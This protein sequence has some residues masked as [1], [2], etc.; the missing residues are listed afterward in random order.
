MPRYL[1]MIKAAENQGEPPQS[2]FDAMD[3]L[4]Q[5]AIKDGSM[6]DTGGLAGT[7]DSTAVRLSG[8]KI[9]VLDGPFSEA[10]EV[11]GGY[12]IM[13]FESAEKAREA[14]VE[15]M[16]LHQKHWPEFE[17]VSEIRQIFGPNDSE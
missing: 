7:A 9:T 6:V 4:V 12:A 8:G 14:A 11:V 17:G 15:F 1:M 2:L 16:E 10:K 3:E 13:R 5:N